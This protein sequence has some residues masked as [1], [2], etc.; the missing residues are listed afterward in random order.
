M[1]GD[2]R[3]GRCWQRVGS[4]RVIVGCLWLAGLA[5]CDRGGGTGAG[6][7]STPTS[8]SATATGVTGA[9]AAGPSEPRVPPLVSPPEPSLAEGLAAA[10]ARV[11]AEPASGE[12]WGRY[13][14]A[15]EAAE[16]V[17]EAR[18]CYARAV[19]LDPASAGWVHLLG[20]LELADQPEKAV[21]H[22]ASAVAL[23]GVGAEASRVRLAQALVERGRFAEATPHLEALVSEQPGHA[24]ARLELARVRFLEQRVGEVADL[25]APCLTNP[26]TARPALLLL[27]Q[28]R[29][30]E[31]KGEEAAELVRRAS[32]MARPFDWP[33]PYQRE[34]QGYRG[35]RARQAEQVNVL[36]GQRRY[37][38]ADALLSGLLE[39]MPDEPE[40]LLLAGR[41]LLLQ[42]RC[43]DAERRMREHL[44]VL[45]D[46]LNGLTQRS[47]RDRSKVAGRFNA[48]P[49]SSPTGN[50]V[51]L[52]VAARPFEVAGRFNAL[53]HSPL[54]PG[55]QFPSRSQRDRS[56]VAGRFNALPHSSPTGNAV[57]LQ[58]AARP[59]E[60][61]RAFQRPVPGSPLL[62]RRGATVQVRPCH[63]AN[64]G[65]AV[66]RVR[67]PRQTS[68]SRMRRMLRGGSSGDWGGWL[69]E[70]V[71]RGGGASLRDADPRTCANR[72]LKRHGYPRCVAPRL[73]K[74]PSEAWRFLSAESVDHGKRSK[75]M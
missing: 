70:W 17:G 21:V 47:Q 19:E 50:A 54:P 51:P 45:P 10:R 71:W 43:A 29:G 15:L 64:E 67:Q 3:T 38:E 46:S 39:R 7:T 26:Y 37:A 49:H 18:E 23:G 14:Q 58:V 11:L 72:G 25:L 36:L 31:G 57:P 41:S 75:T 60:G 35:D 40:F 22:L 56:K 48:L 30:R 27:G 44:R 73:R 62:S 2:P 59:F 9:V 61:C 66:L 28:V 55:T 42:R 12:A 63:P 20:L 33:D 24:A 68:G 16:F 32:G 74:A 65:N 1:N 69:G 8:T 34:V 13:G 5:G 4:L 52:Q 6:P 53:P